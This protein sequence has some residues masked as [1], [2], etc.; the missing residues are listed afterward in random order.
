MVL[1]MFEKHLFLEHVPN[2]V[3]FDG[4]MPGLPSTNAGGQ[5]QGLAD[6]GNSRIPKKRRYRILR[7]PTTVIEEFCSHESGM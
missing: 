6:I 5:D 4:P 1:R 7:I 3:Q 2:G